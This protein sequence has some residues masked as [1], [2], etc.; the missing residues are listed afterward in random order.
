MNSFPKNTKYVSI[1]TSKTNNKQKK[2]S[3][4]TKTHRIFRKKMLSK[5]IKLGNTKRK[6][7]FLKKIYKCYAK[8][9]S[10][11]KKKEPYHDVLVD[12]E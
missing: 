10:K 12:E 7:V 11:K 2:S 9:D 8:K 6:N 3:R 5:S 1:T 4:K